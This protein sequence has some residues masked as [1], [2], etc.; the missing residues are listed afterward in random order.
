MTTP[1]KQPKYL[2]EILGTESRFTVRGDD[3]LGRII[4]KYGI[5]KLRITLLG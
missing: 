5:D 2:V 3:E 1:A 4:A